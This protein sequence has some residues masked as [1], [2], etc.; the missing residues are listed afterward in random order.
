MIQLRI[1]SKQQRADFSSPPKS[2]NRLQTHLHLPGKVGSRR[3]TADSPI[4]A[5]RVP[6]V[7]HTPVARTNLTA[8][9]SPDVHTT[10]GR[11]MVPSIR[12]TRGL[13]R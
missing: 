1:V 3:V 13:P 11:T 6:V 12:D 2:R 9:T 4:R 7:V 5:R 10:R 8:H